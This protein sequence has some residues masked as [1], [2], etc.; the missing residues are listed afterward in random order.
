MSGCKPPVLRLELKYE[1]G[2]V[3]I[4][5]VFGGDVAYTTIRWKRNSSPACKR[6]VK[7]FRLICNDASLDL[8]KTTIEVLQAGGLERLEQIENQIAW[9]GE[10]SNGSLIL[11]LDANF[12]INSLI[13]TQ[14]DAQDVEGVMV[15]K[16]R[17]GI[18]GKSESE[19]PMTEKEIKGYF[20][21]N[22]TKEKERGVEF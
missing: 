13:F 8:Q 11:I 2:M 12:Q 21:S 7:E 22:F 10:F 15:G 3:L 1:S 18:L 9:G 14:F 20:G 4:G 19:L 16:L 6:F 5:A 17:F